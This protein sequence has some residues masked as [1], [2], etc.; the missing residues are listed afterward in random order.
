V[1]ERSET[2][3]PGRTNGNDLVP[4]ADDPGADTIAYADALAELES[5]LAGLERDEP[6]VDQ[7]AER[8]ARAALLI[9]L[10]RGRIAAARLEVERVVTDLGDA[11]QSS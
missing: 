11:G 5:I 3:A 9:R 6:D 1:T 7:L 10:C 2:T 8:V 4:V